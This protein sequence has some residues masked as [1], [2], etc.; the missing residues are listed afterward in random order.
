[1]QPGDG[2]GRTTS[3]D[4]C[5]PDHPGVYCSLVP[6]PFLLPPVPQGDHVMLLLLLLRSSRKKGHHRGGCSLQWP[7]ASREHACLSAIPS[8]NFA[9]SKLKSP[10]LLSRFF[11]NPAF[12]R[13]LLLYRGASSQRCR[14]WS[15]YSL[16]RPSYQRRGLKHPS[17]KPVL[18]NLIYMLEPLTKSAL[19]LHGKSFVTYI[20]QL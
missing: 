14:S 10:N 19:T 7:V 11:H 5:H 18:L 12:F 16:A 9:H 3:R 1:M 13:L 8:S 17:A 2:D 4:C 6:Q 15:K 20:R